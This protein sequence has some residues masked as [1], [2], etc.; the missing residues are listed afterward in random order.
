MSTCTQHQGHSHRHGSACGHVAI[1]HAGHT[2][3]LHDGHLHHVH[4]DHVDEHVLEVNATNPNQCT[5]SHECDGHDKAHVHGPD[6]GHERVPHGDHVD[7]LVG[8]HLHHSHGNHCDNHGPVSV[9][10]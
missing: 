1:G 7:Y 3:Y 4:L 9:K 10:R 5:S 8:D 6:C 2:D